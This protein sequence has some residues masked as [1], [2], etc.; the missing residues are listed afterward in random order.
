MSKFNNALAERLH[1]IS[2]EGG[3]DDEIGSVD[4]LGWA[5]LFLMEKAILIEDSQGFVDAEVFDTVQDVG[6]EWELIE[7]QYTEFWDAQDDSNGGQS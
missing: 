1:E 5:G 3:H 2:L 7:K 4:E 6:I